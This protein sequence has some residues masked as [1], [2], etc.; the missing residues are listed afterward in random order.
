MPV[1]TISCSEARSYL[2][3][4]QT[5]KQKSCQDAAVPCGYRQS[6]Q[7]SRGGKAES[8][9]EAV[10]VLLHFESFPRPLLAQLWQPGAARHCTE[11]LVQRQVPIPC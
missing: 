1:Y 3:L 9:G 7:A 2:P 4:P 8:V 11:V 6:D 5:L 10:V